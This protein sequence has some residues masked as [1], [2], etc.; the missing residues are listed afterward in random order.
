MTPPLHKGQMYVQRWHETSNDAI[1]C[2]SHILDFKCNTLKVETNNKGVTE[3]MTPALLRGGGL[4]SLYQ[5][6]EF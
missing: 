6:E 1:V 3:I 2:D 5:A 4:G